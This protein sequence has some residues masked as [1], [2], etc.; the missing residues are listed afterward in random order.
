MDNE[1][2]PA[3]EWKVQLAKE[4]TGNVPVRFQRRK[5]YSSGVDDLW[6]IDLMDFTQNFVSVNR[7][8]RYALIVIDVFS[9]YVF[10]VPMKN[11]NAVTATEAFETI[12]KESHVKPKMITC[13]HGSKFLNQNFKK[14]LE[15]KTISKFIAPFKMLSPLLLK[16]SFGPYEK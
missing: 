8:H 4:M 15:K 6:A 2:P 10:G 16:E 11:K 7:H 5:M 13:D 12:L 1:K 3:P 9:R 14:M